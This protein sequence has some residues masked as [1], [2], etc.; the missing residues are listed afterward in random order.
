MESS[1]QGT[2]RA[3]LVVGIVHVALLTGGFFA[4]A[5]SFGFPDILRAPAA[6]RLAAFHANQGAIVAAY[7]AM[8]LTGITQ[9]ALAGLGYRAV[10][11]RGSTLAVLALV[12]GVLGGAWQAMGFIRWAITIPYL[13]DA[14]AAGADPATITL[15][16]G[17]LNR[18][19]GMAV[20]EHLGFVGQ[21]L[22]TL[23]ISF[24]GLAAATAPRGL[25][26]IGIAFGV[27]LLVASLE[28]LGGPFE[29]LGPIATSITAAW[30]GWLLM[31]GVSFARGKADARAPFGIVSWIALAAL[32]ALFGGATLM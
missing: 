18:Y 16:E 17:L 6:E 2:R 4:L 30:F 31:L 8:A 32:A 27:G 7:Y 14:S 28:Q 13:A 15:M 24:A 10:D 21:G 25:S 23:L 22:W 1:V 29:A 26:Y 20:G 19:A 12:F 5:A 9:I 11:A 3:F